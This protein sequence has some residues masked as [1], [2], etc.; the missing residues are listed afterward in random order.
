MAD[1]YRHNPF[2]PPTVFADRY[3]KA[4]MPLPFTMI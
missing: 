4:P 1:Q 3:R 2:D